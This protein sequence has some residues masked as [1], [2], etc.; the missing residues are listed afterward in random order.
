MLAADTLLMV[1][2]LRAEPETLP[3]SLRLVPLSCH[4]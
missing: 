1:K 4:W 2:L 3:P